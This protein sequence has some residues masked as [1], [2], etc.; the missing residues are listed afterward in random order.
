MPLCSTCNSLPLRAL[1]R[2]YNSDDKTKRA[3]RLD[4]VSWLTSDEDENDEDANP[5]GF[6]FR[7]RPWRTHKTIRQIHDS[8]PKCDLC[9]IFSLQ[10]STPFSEEKSCGSVHMREDGYLGSTSKPGDDETISMVFG[11]YHMVM[12]RVSNPE[13]QAY[14]SVRTITGRCYHSKYCTTVLM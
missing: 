5:G 13:W 9:R 4:H 6:Y 10:L 3:S 12:Y 2:L 14:F 1:D 7:L 11:K 8:A